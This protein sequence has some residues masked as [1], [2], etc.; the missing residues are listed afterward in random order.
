MQV[1]LREMRASARLLDIGCGAGRNTAPLARLGW[2][3]FG[4]DLSRPMVEA[5]AASVTA[6]QLTDR[7]RLLLAPM[8]R[9]PFASDSFDF[10]VAHGIWNLARSDS[11]FRRGV[12]DAAR[13][14]RRGCALFVFTFSRTTLADTVTPVPGE[15]FVFTEF[16]GEPQCFLTREQLVA[17]LGACGFAPDPL[18]PLRELNRRQPGSLRTG[19]APVIFEGLFRR[20]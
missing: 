5:A 17:E 11:E 9:L 15:T 12:Q 13:V 16:A 14:A 19:N 20:A 2:R 18:I 1:A 8:D 6:Q 7:V 3:V 10:I 4:T